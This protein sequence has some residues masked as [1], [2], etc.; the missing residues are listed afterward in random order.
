[1]AF[2]EVEQLNLLKKS[3]PFGARFFYFLTGKF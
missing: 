2:I 1:M 3:E